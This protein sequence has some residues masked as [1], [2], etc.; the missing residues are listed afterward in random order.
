MVVMMSSRG[1][2]SLTRTEVVHIFLGCYRELPNGQLFIPYDHAPNS[3]EHGIFYAISLNKTSAEI[4]AYWA[5]FLFSGR[6]SPPY[7][8]E[9]RE[10]PI[11]IV[12]N[13][14][15]AIGYIER[16]KM[17]GRLHIVDEVSS[18]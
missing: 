14:L 13:D 10:K 7:R 8:V 5:R 12:A 16:E 11:D 18:P 6:I 9:N 4:S 2:T 1:V 3:W 17:D 15:R